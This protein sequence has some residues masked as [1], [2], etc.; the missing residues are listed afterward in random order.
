MASNRPARGMG[1]DGKI[2]VFFSYKPIVHVADN[3]SQLLRRGGQRENVCYGKPQSLLWQ[4]VN[5][6]LYVF[7]VVVKMR[8]DA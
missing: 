6:S 7:G 4:S 1:I 3:R 5:Q 2:V 8:R